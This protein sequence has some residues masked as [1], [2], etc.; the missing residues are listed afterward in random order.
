MNGRIVIFGFGAV[1]RATA[2]LLRSKGYE[3]LVAQRNRPADLPIGANFVGC[4]VLDANAVQAAVDGA[5]QIVL[6]VGFPYEGKVWR[7][8][9]PRAMTNVLAACETSK[10]RMVFLDNL[11][12]YG[13]QRAP[14]TETMSLTD[15]GVKPKVRAEVTRLWLD[16]SRAGRVRVAAIRA[17]DFYGPH[18]LLSHLGEA[19][20][21]AI[22]K[23]KASS[24]I[25][26][27]DT[28]HDFAYVPDIARAIVTL[29]DAPDD[30]YGQAWHVP[31]A[32]TR[33]PRQI[34]ALGATALGKPLKISALP[35]FL[36]PILGLAS[37][38]MREFSE[39]RFQ[40][41]RPYH[42]DSAKFASRFWSDA[43]PFE[44]GAA[45]TARSFAGT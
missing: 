4:D 30:V 35:L 25:A 16:A 40:W 2:S 8:A 44:V 18:V 9:W 10:A 11:Y 28:L 42:V 45:E 7:E 24:L 41:D 17:S 20:F 14:L 3:I 26:P 27:P 29:L 23:G 19:A 34:L 43:T 32:P 22:A 21:G 6:A 36:L 13:P 31:T 37:P 12:L 1:G 39:M 38:F 15:Y 5:T 33:T